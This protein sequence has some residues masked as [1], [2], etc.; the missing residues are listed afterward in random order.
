[1][2][3][4]SFHYVQQP[5]SFFP[6][7]TIFRF[8]S[9]KSLMHF[10]SLFL[11]CVQNR[12][13]FPHDYSKSLQ[14]LGVM[15]HDIDAISSHLFFFPPAKIRWICRPRLKAWLKSSL[16]WN[17]ETN[18]NQAR[19]ATGPKITY[20]IKYSYPLAKALTD[21]HIPIPFTIGLQACAICWRMPQIQSD[22]IKSYCGSIDSHPGKETVARERE[23]D[24]ENRRNSGDDIDWG[25]EFLW[26]NGKY[27][28]RRAHPVGKK[29]SKLAKISP[30][31]SSRNFKQMIS[32][33]MK[34]MNRNS[35]RSL[36]I[37]WKSALNC[38]LPMET[39]CRSNR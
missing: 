8:C 3:S 21:P 37:N 10:P 18:G 17:S 29:P 23:R 14:Q 34:A 12:F 6:L 13:S 25:M 16:V 33:T 4:H 38:F 35:F 7:K 15:F 19:N 31:V 27:T 32:P 30:V 20:P 9:L 22:C 28:C 2:Y 1:M 11:L 5:C 36:N 24:E 26:I 39:I